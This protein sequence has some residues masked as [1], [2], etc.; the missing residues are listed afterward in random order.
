M[1][2]PTYVKT[3]AKRI[4]TEKLSSAYP[5]ILRELTEGQNFNRFANLCA[6]RCNQLDTAGFIGM[7]VNP[8]AALEDFIE[9]AALEYGKKYLE[10]RQGTSKRP[11]D[12]PAH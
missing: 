3:I 6:E 12:E 11:A 4:L 1:I 8:K 7:T 9:Q 2:Y 10:K 5:G